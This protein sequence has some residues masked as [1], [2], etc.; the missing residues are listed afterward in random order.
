M[1]ELYAIMLIAI[2]NL[3][4][5]LALFFAKSSN[6]T[7]ALVTMLRGLRTSAMVLPDEEARNGVHQIAGNKLPGLT[8]PIKQDFNDLKNLI[9]DGWPGEDPKPRYEMAGQTAYTDIGEDGWEHVELLH[10]NMNAFIT[11]AVNAP[12]LSS[13]GGMVAGYPAQVI[14]NFTAFNA[15]Y[16]LF[17]SSRE[18]ATA[19][20]AKIKAN[21]LL[22]D[23][24]MNGFMK[25]GVE[26]VFRNDEDG[27]KRY[28]FSVL[29]KLVSSPGA[30]SLD[31]HLKKAG[32]N[33]PVTEATVIIQS[34]TGT[35]KTENPDVEGNLSFTGIDA[36][37]YKVTVKV[38][39]QPDIVK[40]K[41]VNVGTQARMVVEIP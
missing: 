20:A 9:R 26:S 25:F 34:E 22:Y 28:T 14:A 33:E 21:N 5:D 31:M 8:E 7:A 12:I 40:T 15:V 37:I 16:P 18:T 11:D 24:C 35:P 6:Y 30:A 2:N 1:A 23:T 13:P 10:N 36:D 29:K 32:T 27:Q 38:T 39:G 19:A 3:E 17:L 41:E 4:T